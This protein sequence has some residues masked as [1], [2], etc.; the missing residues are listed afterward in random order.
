MNIDL[1][2]SQIRSSQGN[3]SNAIK[4]INQST[5]L[6]SQRDGTHT[7]L[8]NNDYCTKYQCNTQCALVVF[9]DMEW[10]KSG[11]QFHSPSKEATHANNIVIDY[12]DTNITQEGMNESINTCSNVMQHMQWLYKE[13]TVLPPSPL[14][15]R[16][17]SHNSS[18]PA[19][20]LVVEYHSQ[21]LHI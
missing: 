21:C 9:H 5:S 14:K 18:P 17:H 10:K 20:S 1:C 6:P 8:K 12:T 4:R 16:E 2:L 3:H 11:M 13:E 7:M 15:M 19:N